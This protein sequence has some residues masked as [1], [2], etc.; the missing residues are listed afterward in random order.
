[1]LRLLRLAPARLENMQVDLP[2]VPADQQELRRSMNGLRFTAAVRRAL[3]DA[4]HEATMRRAEFVGTEHVLL[5]LLA[6]GPNMATRVI[7]ACGVEPASLRE[8]VDRTVG[9]SRMPSGE[10]PA[11]PYTSRTK[12]VLEL[13]MAEA[14]ELG[15]DV[16]GTQHVL[17]GL[18]RDRKDI[19]AR[20]MSHAGITADAARDQVVRLQRD[21]VTE[22][23]GSASDASSLPLSDGARLGA[24]ETIRQLLTRPEVAAV[25]SKHRID[26]GRLLNDLKDLKD[27]KI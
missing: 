15:D 1:M 17:L 7:E 23:D 12:T 9:G 10:Y 4:R 22:D 5:G 18:I 14:A 25:F 21:G 13:A 19:G 27:P 6:T 24:A 3:D 11:L 8:F 26:V 20:A 16:V 2:R